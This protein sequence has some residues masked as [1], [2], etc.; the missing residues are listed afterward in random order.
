MNNGMSIIGNIS[1]RDIADDLRAIPIL[2]SQSDEEFESFK[3]F[4]RGITDEQAAEF[5]QG[6]ER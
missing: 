1:R 3:T 6:Y 5:F 4:M 2:E